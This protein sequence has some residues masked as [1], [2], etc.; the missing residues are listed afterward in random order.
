[1]NP[2][3]VVTCKV[4]LSACHFRRKEVQASGKKEGDSQSLF[5]IYGLAHAGH[6]SAISLYKQE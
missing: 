5:G 3:V 6:G 2:T 1:M 4:A